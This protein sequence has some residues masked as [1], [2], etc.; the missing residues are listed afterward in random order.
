M[1]LTPALLLQGEYLEKNGKQYNETPILYN[2]QYHI[3]MKILAKSDALQECKPFFYC[4][5]S[6]TT[7]NDI[8]NKSGFYKDVQI[9]S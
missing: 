9:P 8:F 6:R 1:L 4:M 3:R 2:I 5:P 7:D